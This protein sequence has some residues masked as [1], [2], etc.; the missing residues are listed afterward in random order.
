M[1]DDIFPNGDVLKCK[2]SLKNTTIFLSSNFFVFF[3]LIVI[4][5]ELLSVGFFH[6]IFLFFF[7]NQVRVNPVHDCYRRRNN[8]F[9]FFFGAVTFLVVCLLRLFFFS[10]LSRSFGSL[11]FF[12]FQHHA[13]FSKNWSPTHLE[14]RTK[15]DKNGLSE[16]VENEKGKKT[17]QQ[18]MFLIL[19]IIIVIICAG[20][21]ARL[22]LSFVRKCIAWDETAA[23]SHDSWN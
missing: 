14:E 19:I 5:V 9:F 4:S 7:S 22:P 17:S 2:R 12:D 18:R 20:V 3:G 16:R 21:C 23:R 8:R 15:T 10:F 13:L 6:F 1:C 11:A